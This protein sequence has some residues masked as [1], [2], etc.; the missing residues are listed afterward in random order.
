MCYDKD[1][2]KGA[3]TMIL[4]KPYAFLI[5][6]FRWIHLLLL[7]PMAY[8]IHRSFRIVSFFRTYVS[9]NYTTSIINIAAEHISFFMYLAVLFII[10]SVLAI[11]YLMRQKKKS[12]KL[13]FFILLYYIFLFVLIGLT[14]SILS[15]MEHNL[16]TAQTARAYRDISVVLCLPQYFFFLYTLIR[17]IGFDIKKFNFAGD[18]K[19]LEITDIDSEEFEFHV[20]VEGYKIERTARRFVREMTYYVKENTFVFSCI[21]AVFV[22]FIGTL[23]YLHY[24]VYNKTYRTTDKMTHNSF[25]LQVADSMVSNLSYNGNMITEGKYY[26]VLKLL[27]ENK[28]NRDYDLDYTNFRLVLNNK[29][30][31]PLLD[32]GEHFVDF[33]KPYLGEKIK[34]Q[35]KEYYTLSYE[36]DASDLTNEYTIKILESIDFKV[37]E[38]AAKYKL[39]KL[40]PPK[41]DKVEDVDTLEIGKIINLKQTNL[42]YSTFQLNGY[43]FVG[44]YMYDYEYC[45]TENN[46]RTLKDNITPNVS[47]TIEKTTLLVLNNNFHLDPESDYFDALRTD[48][49]FA[50]QFLALRT[51]KNGETKLTSMY[52]RTTS[53]MKNVF[54]FEIRQEVLEAEQVELLLTVRDKRYIYRLK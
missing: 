6:H 49:K 47:G 53:F 9:N 11:Y 30:I 18:L 20:N 16:I 24:G 46:C 32:R 29:N 17:G 44:S 48:A 1:K 39:I 19:D 4:K 28:T 23:L 52:N 33:G 8:L 51:T 35:S 40:N 38:I 7:V 54:V 22:I 26:L 27:I 41:I 3:D 14:Y 12:T 25:T 21:A 36:I 2:I 50:S 15:S 13:Y 45:K 42:D 34:K 10:L 43:Q 31:Y 37:G 5:R